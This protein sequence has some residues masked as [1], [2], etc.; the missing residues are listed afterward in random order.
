[1]QVLCV[2][3]IL[4]FSEMKQNSSWRPNRSKM[5]KIAL[6]F[7]FCIAPTILASPKRKFLPEGK[8]VL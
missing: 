8:Q 2:N 5:F 1:M 7:M 3:L 4:K 6:F